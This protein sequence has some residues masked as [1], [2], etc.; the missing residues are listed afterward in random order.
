MSREKKKGRQVFG[1]VV[2]EGLI[3]VHH[4]KKRKYGSIPRGIQL[5]VGVQEHRAEENPAVLPL[6]STD[7]H[8]CSKASFI[9]NQ[10]DKG[11]Q[12]S[13]SLKKALELLF[14]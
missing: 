9:V 2:D 11:R 14:M 3:T 4:L 7:A 6:V 12:L 8:L 1:A 13:F 10:A 5:N